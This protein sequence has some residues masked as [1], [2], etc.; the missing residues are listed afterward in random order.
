MLICC[1]SEEAH[2]L[3][4]SNE[5]DA[6]LTMSS[7]EHGATMACQA[8]LAPQKKYPELPIAVDLAVPRV[9]LAAPGQMPGVF[10]FRLGILFERLLS[11]A[12][13]LERIT[14]TQHVSAVA[15]IP[16]LIS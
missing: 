7:D 2:L 10:Q 9:G 5:L 1:V 13:A 4:A 3:Q 16:E 8:S 6:F 14:L 11:V 15:G 12:S